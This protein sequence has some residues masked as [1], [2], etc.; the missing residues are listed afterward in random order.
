MLVLPPGAWFLVKP[1]RVVAPG[2][3]GIPCQSST[4]C[5][6]DPARAPEAQQL[7]AEAEA[8]VSA[9]VDQ[10][11]HP[12]RVVF[13]STE[14][15]ARAFGLGRRASVAVGTLGIVIGPRAWHDY[16]V[17]HEMIHYLQGRRL[18]V[19]RMLFM[20]RWFIEGMAYGLSEDPRFPLPYPYEA[21][22]LEFLAWYAEVGRERLWV[23][24]RRL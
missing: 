4:W 19:L 8:F 5:V 16:L 24:G 17:R 15:C 22:R 1:V 10:I 2:L 13:C 23:E 3:V 6:D 14:D 12:P 7:Y 11:G 18:N 20:P 21:Y 9:K